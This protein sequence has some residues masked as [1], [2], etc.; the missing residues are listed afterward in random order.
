[1]ANIHSNKVKEAV[2]YFE[3]EIRNKLRSTISEEN[4]KE[5]LEVLNLPFWKYRWYLYEVWATMHTIDAFKD[6]DVSFNV[7]SSGTLAVERA[8]QQR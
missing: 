1:M 2:G 3:K 8:R 4:V 5:L 6:F 7:D